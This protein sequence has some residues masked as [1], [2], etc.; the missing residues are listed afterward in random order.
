ML[1]ERIGCVAAIMASAGVRG[2]NYLLQQVF[3]QV[4]E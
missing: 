3:P 1:P 2:G 4:M